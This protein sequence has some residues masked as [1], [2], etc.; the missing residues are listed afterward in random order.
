M[1]EGPEVKK[2]CT[3]VESIILNE[4]LT[5]ITI[6]SGKYIEKRPTHLDKIKEHFPLI[7][8]DVFVKGKS[9]FIRLEKSFTI[10]IVHGMTGKW[11]LEKT[12]NSRIHINMKYNDLYLEDSRNFSTITICN[13]EKEYESR[14]NKLGPDVL[15]DHMSYDTFYSRLNLKSKTLVSV[16]LLDQNKICGIGNYLRCE[17]L[18]Y[19]GIDSKKRCCD[20]TQEEQ[21]RLYNSSVNICRYFANK[22]YILRYTPNDFERTWFVYMQ[23]K[24]PFEKPVYKTKINSR[25]F[26]HI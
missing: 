22:T 2:Y 9:I 4:Q 5:D 6:L 15:S 12:K 8:V 16:V 26:H 20:L 17:I 11:K 18:W 23:D 25:T 24:D 3:F 7:V 13:S 14:L 1:P 21:D 19:A 10:I